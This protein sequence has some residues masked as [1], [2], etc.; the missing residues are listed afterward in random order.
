MST[1]PET[2]NLLR[3]RVYQ[4]TLKIMNTAKDEIAYRSAADSF[5]SLGDYKDAPQLYKEC[6]EQAKI[7]HNDSVY[8][9]AK[10]A[11]EA[12]AAKTYQDANKL[13]QQITLLQ[14]ILGWKDSEALIAH[15]RQKIEEIQVREEEFLREAQKKAAAQRLAAAKAAR[16]R[17]IVLTIVAL[18]VVIGT[19]I[20]L[21][22]KYV[23]VPNQ[24]Y[25]AAMAHVEAGEFVEGYNELIALDG[26]KDSTEQAAAI[27]EDYKA[28]LLQTAEI[29]ETV[30]FGCYQQTARLDAVPEDLEW[31]VLDKKDGKVL[32][33]S[34]Q[35]LHGSKFHD[36]EADTTWETS[37]VRS[38][39]NT[40]FYNAAF[41]TEDQA[42]IVITLVPADANPQYD[43]NQ[44]SDTQDQV[45]LLSINEVNTY[46]ATV[47]AAK[48][49]PTTYAIST[50]TYIN[51]DIGYCD[52]WL[53]TMGSDA[54]SVTSV[55]TGGVLNYQ[56]SKVDFGKFSLRP[57]I[58]VD[59]A[60]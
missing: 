44:G 38:W 29:G 25:D 43:T 16:I 48:C 30:L 10:A 7:Y 12:N 5:E 33:L 58:W 21:L 57:A 46:F 26:H 45:F 53:R 8:N 35:G 36:E 17:K 3:E 50:G 47:D 13:K 9:T 31:L 15:C 18:L 27:Y 20:F 34:L 49:E 1:Q 2:D 24:Q 52:W 56:G 40:E 19:T 23:W 54:Q 51:Y 42:Q 55:N 32:L 6:D 14:T 59:P 4:N 60:E 41:D 22:N 28:Q 11:I 39:L 37:W